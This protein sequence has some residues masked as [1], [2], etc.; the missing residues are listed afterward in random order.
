MSDSNRAEARAQFLSGTDWRAA[1]V[2]PLPGDASFRHYFRLQDGRRHALLMDAPPDTENTATYVL[3]ARHLVSLGLSAPRIEA[4]DQ[5]QGFAVIEDFGEYTF[6]KLLNDGADEEFLYE[7]A[8][9]ALTHLHGEPSAAEIDCP[10]YNEQALLNEASLLPDWYLPAMTGQETSEAVRESYMEAWQVA[11]D[12]MPSFSPTLVLR[13]YHVDNLMVLPERPGLAGCGLLDFQDALI[14]H[15]AYD[16]VSLLEDARRDVSDQL[17]IRMRN[18]YR[19]RVT[20][21]DQAA[22]DAWYV[23]LGVQRHAKVAGIFVRLYV[24]DGKPVYLPHIPR[25]MALLS[26]SLA[27]PCLSPVKKW[28]DEHL[29][30]PTKS[31]PEFDPAEVRRLINV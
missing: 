3:V 12:A 6:T 13:D 25:V 31:L 30:E 1:K 11:I 8:V 10:E 4:L 28:F 26:R 29:S 2:T 18:R 22:F 24:R 9:D 5:A 16:L 15:P 19:E 23:L 7:L 27:S 21:E 20:I 17:T 14:G